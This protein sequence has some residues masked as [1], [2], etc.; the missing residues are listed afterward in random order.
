MKPDPFDL[1]MHTPMEYSQ[2]GIDNEE[3]V[4]DKIYF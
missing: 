2:L 3:K 4:F 1:V